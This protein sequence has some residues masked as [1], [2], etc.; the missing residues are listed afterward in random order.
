MK[1]SIYI[2][3][4]GFTALYAFFELFKLILIIVGKVSEFQ[5]IHNWHLYISPLPLS[6]LIWNILIWKKQDK[7]AS[8]IVCLIVFG[9][10]YNCY[11]YF[12]VRKEN[13]I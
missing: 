10:F 2:L 5:G 12:K 7:K 4:F 11:Y 9:P 8:N 6:F 13:W 1:K 3:L